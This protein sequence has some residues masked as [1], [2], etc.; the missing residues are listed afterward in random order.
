MLAGEQRGGMRDE[1]YGKG[2]WERTCQWKDGEEWRGLTSALSDMGVL[3]PLVQ[4]RAGVRHGTC[5]VYLYSTCTC[6]CT[7]T[8]AVQYIPST[9]VP[10]GTCTVLYIPSTHAQ[11]SLVPA[12]FF[13]VA[14]YYARRS[15]RVLVHRTLFTTAQMRT[16]RV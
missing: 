1:G 13:F 16:L 7:W 8:C 15:G 4:G 5:R 11:A 12:A 10:A 3:V 2:V 14:L 9:H 6:T